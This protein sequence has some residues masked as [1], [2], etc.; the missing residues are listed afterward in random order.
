MQSISLRNCTLTFLDENFGLK[1]LK[2]SLQL[3]NWLS[4][5]YSI[6][7][8][9]KQYLL[10]LQNKFLDN[11]RHWNEQELLSNFIVPIFTLVNFTTEKFNDFANRGVSATIGEYQLSGNPDGMI[12]TGFREPRIPYFAFQEYKPQTDPTGEPQGQCVAA[13]LV[14]QTLNGNANPVYG[15]YVIGKEWNFVILENKEYC[16]SK[17]Y[18][19]DDEEI[20]DIYRILQGLKQILLTIIH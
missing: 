1:E 8:F 19:A 3:E 4:M 15:C 14:G 12:A 18:A 7:D 2:K 20:F 6:S 16:I 5:P 13:M 9:E 11:V 10:A 17:L